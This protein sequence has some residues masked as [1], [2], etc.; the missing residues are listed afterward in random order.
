MFLGQLA[1]QRWNRGS[2]D[3][4]SAI[5]R[6]QRDFNNI[7]TSILLSFRRS[8]DFWRANQRLENIF[9]K[10]VVIL[11]VWHRHKNDKRSWW[12]HDKH[13]NCMCLYLTVSVCVCVYYPE[14]MLGI[15]EQQPHFA[16]CVWQEH[17]LQGDHVGV[18]QLSQQL[19]ETGWHLRTHS[20]NL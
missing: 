2:T 15:V 20:Y 10:L 13:F 12:P 11:S 16:V 1:L 18:F 6:S 19:R 4:Y 5:S 14:V 3:E 9:K 8:N 17:F 7:C